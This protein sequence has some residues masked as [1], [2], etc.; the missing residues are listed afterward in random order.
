MTTEPDVPPRKDNQEVCWVAVFGANLIVPVLFGWPITER[1]GR[2]GMLA[3]LA[4]L[5]AAWQFF[6]PRYEHLRA[7]LLTGGIAVAVSQLLPLL[8]VFTG[9]LSFSIVGRVVPMSPHDLPDDHSGV[10]LDD[11]SAFAVTILT[12]TQL[13]VTAMVAGVAFRAA[14]RRL[15]GTA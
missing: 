1:G 8:Q 15:L 13:W 2:V 3:A 5:L 12:G 11:V 6:I 14:G 4:V 10:G 7:V 9:L